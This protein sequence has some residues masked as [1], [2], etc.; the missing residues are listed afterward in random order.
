MS[1]LGL[2][3]GTLRAR[4]RVFSLLAGRS[5]AAFGS[6]SIVEPPVR[7]GGEERIRVGSGVYVGAGS[8]LQALPGDGIALEIGD[9]TSIS[10]ALVV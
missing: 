4:A 3:R 7:I 9:G 6:G 1:F 5:F 10:G 2:Y 8:W